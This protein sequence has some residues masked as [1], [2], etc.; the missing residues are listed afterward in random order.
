MAAIAGNDRPLSFGPPT[1]SVARLLAVWALSDAPLAA[2]LLLAALPV[3]IG[4]WDL[5]SPPL[6]LSQEM[7]W[8]LLFNL[9]GAWQMYLG[10]VPHV[11][12]HEPVG[13]LNFALTAMGFNVVGVGPRAFLAGAILMTGVIFL[14]AS[15]VA[16][17]RLP[18]LPAAIFV[19]FVSLLALMPAN[20]GDEPNAYSFAMS[21]NRYGWSCI[22]ILF[23]I[24]FLPPRRGDGR[25]LASAWSDI[26]I[27]IALLL[28]MFYLKMTYFVVGLAALPVAALVCS[29]VRGA[30]FGWYLL[31]LGMMA[32]ALAP[33]NHAYWADLF[34][35]AE[36]GQLR[37]TLTFHINNFFG[38]TAEY[39][40]YIAALAIAV[41]MA[42][43]G[44]APMRLP[45]ATAFILATALV[46]LSQNAQTHGLPAAVII[47][48]LFYD[49]LRERRLQV[50][51]GS[52][53]ALLLSLLVFPLLSIA[54]ALVSLTGYEL[55]ASRQTLQT[56]DG[57][58][59]HGLAVPAEKSGLL[60][61]FANPRGDYHLLN[62]A[63]MVSTRYELSPSEY[64]D[65]LLDAVA[66]LGTVSGRHRR[67]VVLDQVN[68]LP[69]M[70][71]QVPPRGGNLWSGP[72]APVQP[73]QHVF[74][75]ADCVLIPKFSTYSPWTKAAVELYGPYLRRHF[76]V[77]AESQSWIMMGRKSP[78]AP[79]DHDAPRPGFLSTV[80][81]V[82]TDSSDAP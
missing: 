56:V 52:S 47:A 8:D 37:D 53:I 72:G 77:R 16:W 44:D 69:F 46:L 4:I 27:A 40:P 64:V 14:S 34:A 26:A 7:T 76:A 24:L 43:R 74:A 12:F 5:L 48:F 11:D 61:A 38:H 41:W 1:P 71:G 6:V 28:A 23:L 3:L 31:A 57:T 66:L 49:I 78:S 65:T 22:A 62:R 73:A 80:K 50:R 33:V 36:A 9:A 59:L 42:W 75:E 2:V 81:S 60:A 32:L 55:K 58:N 68:P 82:E 79:A 67:I 39:A 51:P 19:A 54:A 13:Q 17:R 45:M 29:H 63:R 10:H 70:L 18:A 15:I 35:A 25:A 30:L 21:Y 20:V